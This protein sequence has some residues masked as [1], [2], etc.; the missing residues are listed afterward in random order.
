[1]QMPKIPN[2]RLLLFHGTDNDA[3]NAII[4]GG[5]DTS[6][7]LWETSFGDRTYMVEAHYDLEM[8]AYD[9]L[10]Q[11]T[12]LSELPALKFARDAAKIANATKNDQNPDIKLLM[13]SIP[14]SELEQTLFH[15]MSGEAEQNLFYEIMDHDLNRLID[16]GIIEWWEVQIE[17]GYTP[18]LRLFYLPF[19]Q[20]SYVMPTDLYDVPCIKEFM[21]AMDPD[22]T[23]T[24]FLDQIDSSKVTAVIKITPELREILSKEERRLINVTNQE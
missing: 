2:D 5:F 15:D 22:G 10:A 16:E 9:E 18:Q 21:K 24:D 12:D 20:D 3:V 4:R 8:Q 1:M 13:F 7:T 11:I 19:C 14:K 23:S 6:Y 17:N